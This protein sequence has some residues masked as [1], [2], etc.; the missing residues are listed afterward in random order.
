MVGNLSSCQAG[1]TGH[2]TACQ[3]NEEPCTI[4]HQSAALNARQLELAKLKEKEELRCQI[5]KVSGRK[6]DRISI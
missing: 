5:T 4:R 1:L 3:S 6:K 2:V